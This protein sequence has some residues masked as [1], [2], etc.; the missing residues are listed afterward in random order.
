MSF[1]LPYDTCTMRPSP[2]LNFQYNRYDVSN[3]QQSQGINVVSRQDYMKNSS[4]IP[5]GVSFNE[6][7]KVILFNL[8]SCQ[9]L[10]FFF[11]DN[12]F[13]TQTG[14]FSLMFFFPSYT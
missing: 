3:K 10:T 8:K 1:K 11:G 14:S 9:M 2:T 5:S 13:Q 12:K 7:S 4:F 6:G